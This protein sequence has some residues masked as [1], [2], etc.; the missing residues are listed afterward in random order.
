MCACWKTHLDTFSFNNRF[1]TTIKMNWTTFNYYHTKNLKYYTRTPAHHLINTR[2]ETFNQFYGVFTLFQF[3]C[4]CFSWCS[5]RYCR[6]CGCCC[7]W[8]QKR[9][10]QLSTYFNEYLQMCGL[11]VEL[12]PTTFEF[13]KVI[14]QMFHV[15]SYC[16][17]C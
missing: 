12:R 13:D 15:I 10:F 14:Y 3:W 4:W 7:F 9:C 1:M 5:C 11:L 8:W 17:S 16:F 6:R 2:N